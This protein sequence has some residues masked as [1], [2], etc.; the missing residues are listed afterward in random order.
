MELK[1]RTNR[2]GGTEYPNLAAYYLHSL[3][4]LLQRDKI[5]IAALEKSAMRGGPDGDQ[6][7]VRLIEAD[8]SIIHKSWVQDRRAAWETQVR[9]A[10][11]AGKGNKPQIRQIRQL[12]TAANRAAVGGTAALPGGQQ[13]AS[14]WETSRK[15]VEV[16]LEILRARKEIEKNGGKGL[17]SENSKL[18]DEIK[19]KVDIITSVE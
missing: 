12:V 13:H 17:F 10:T 6:D 9:A 4:A 19:K 5:D 7:L 1:Q 8:P 18:W 14:R 11:K 2:L 16:Y 15:F 3:L